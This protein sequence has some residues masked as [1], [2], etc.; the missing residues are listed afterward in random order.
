MEKNFLTNTKV[1]V[2]NADYSRAIQEV[3]FKLGY[4]WTSS[5]K[6]SIKCTDEPYLYFYE[7]GDIAHS[8]SKDSFDARTSIKE[9][10]I[11]DILGAKNEGMTFFEALEYMKAKEGNKVKIS[12]WTKGRHIYISGG[13]FYVNY[14][15][16]NRVITNSVTVDLSEINYDNWEI[17]QE[18]SKYKSWEEI[19]NEIGCGM[20]SVD[21][22]TYVHTL[23]SKSAE[24]FLSICKL[25]KH[26]GYNS[27]DMSK[28]EK[29]KYVHFITYN[30]GCKE[31][32]VE[33]HNN[34]F[35]LPFAFHNREDAEAFIQNHPDLLRAFFMV[36][37]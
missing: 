22:Q 7:D 36:G 35:H 34:F 23:E 27:V 6:S 1:A 2:L 32:R 5:R 33:G 15:H 24:S 21:G 4:K 12:T 9:L 29:N 25:L 14:N 8:D 3:A 19:E 30:R 31:F 13:S 20:F 26:G 16:S 37:E 17:Y 11:A 10:T 18:P 28:L